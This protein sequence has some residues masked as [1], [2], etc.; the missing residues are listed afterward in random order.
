MPY[1]NRKA[2]I[3]KGL[4]L[5]FRMWLGRIRNKETA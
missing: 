1:K 4:Q 5:H 2:L 3:T